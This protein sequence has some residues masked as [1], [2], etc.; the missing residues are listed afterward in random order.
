MI[1]EKKEHEKY[2]CQLKSLFKKLI[3]FLVENNYSWFTCGGTT[4]GAVR[5]KDIIPWDDDIDIFI[6]RD[7]YERL[8]L[9]SE[10]L[11]K[12]GL[13]VKSIYDKGYDHSYA[14]II[15]GNT[16]IWEHPNSPLS[17]LWVDIFPLDNY[18]RGLTGLSAEYKRFFKLFRKYQRGV[19]KIRL[20]SLLKAISRLDLNMFVSHLMSISYF[21]WRNEKYRKEFIRYYASLRKISG[22]NV[23][24]YPDGRACVYNSEWFSDYVLMPFGDFEVRMP[25]G[26]HEYLTLLYGDYMTPPPI[27]QQTC[28]HNM[29]YINLKESLDKKEV[30][31]RLRK[32]EKLV[33]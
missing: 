12:I 1:L 17:G 9:D 26:W 11:S 4:L 16:T 6:P 18:D 31:R 13:K 14:K 7:D 15:E 27:E 22:K 25:I 20:L 2:N 3:D 8:L 21:R 29:C 19:L 10:N 33:L 32:G 28:A 24:S 5:H 30:K 23:V